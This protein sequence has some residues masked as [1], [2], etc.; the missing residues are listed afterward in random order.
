MGS[1]PIPATIN[2]F[3]KLER[4]STKFM[5]NPKWSRTLTDD[6]VEREVLKGGTFRIIREQDS[7]TQGPGG[8]DFVI[9]TNRGKDNITVVPQTD[10]IPR[11]EG[12]EEIVWKRR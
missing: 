11:V 10:S 6:V 12:P 3:I 8:V 2:K 9:R 7:L 5:E 1:I 4:L